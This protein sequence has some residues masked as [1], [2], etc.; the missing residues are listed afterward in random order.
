MRGKVEEK[1][2][3]EV[4]EYLTNFMYTFVFMSNRLALASLLK[5]FDFIDDDDSGF[6][7][8]EVSVDVHAQ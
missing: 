2:L 3:A 1:R 8:K 4:R 7:S 5:A 6:I